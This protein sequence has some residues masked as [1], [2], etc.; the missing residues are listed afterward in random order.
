MDISESINSI[1]HINDE[2]INHII[3]INTINNYN[4]FISSDDYLPYNFNSNR[5]YH[6][7]KKDKFV[8]NF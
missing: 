4:G 7:L 1:T 6:I 3:N 5:N 8:I 2:N